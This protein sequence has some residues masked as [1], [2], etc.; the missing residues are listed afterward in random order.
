MII[1]KINL[2]LIHYSLTTI[3]VIRFNVLGIEGC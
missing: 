3:V 1:K 2:Y